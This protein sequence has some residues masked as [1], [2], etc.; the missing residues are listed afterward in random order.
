MPATRALKGT[1]S[2]GARTRQEILQT[3]ARLAT[4]EGIRHLSIARL[5]DEVG[6]S[7]S[8]LY[9]HFGSKEELQLAT[10]DTAEEIY[11]RDVYER[12]ERI[13]LGVDGAI[14]L[15]DAHLD[16]M[17]RG[18]FPGGC[19]FDAAAGDIALERGPVRDRVVAFQSG[20]VRHLRDNLRVAIDA[21][22]LPPDT[23]LDQISY[24]VTAYL[25]LAHSRLVFDGNA[26]GLEL[27]ARSVRHRLGR[28]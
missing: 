20:W 11:E 22:E 4:V 9:S 3:A 23:D 2:D 25:V 7:K 5:A 28:A 12:L 21:G 14:A 16:H 15:A 1:R 18:V 8:G 26:S 17:R 10:I 6:I 24:D 19:F 27:A 13:P